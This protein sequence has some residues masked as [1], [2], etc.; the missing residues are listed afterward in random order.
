MNVKRKPPPRGDPI[1]SATTRWDDDAKPI[2]PFII[3][4][5]SSW[6]LQPKAREYRTK[7]KDALREAIEVFPPEKR[8]TPILAY[9]N[10]STL[11]TLLSKARRM[12][13]DL[14]LKRTTK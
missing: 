12:D 4:Y 6:N 8:P 13:K 10:S 5:S 11:G 2:L 1:E 9:S 14:T 7:I 3:R